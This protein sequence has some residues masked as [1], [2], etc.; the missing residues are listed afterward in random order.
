M[1]TRAQIGYVTD[2][3][4]V[5]G[6]Y[7]HWDGYPTGVGAILLEEYRTPEAVNALTQYEIRVLGEDGEVEYFGFTDGGLDQIEWDTEAHFFEDW[8]RYG[9][10]YHYLFKDGEWTIQ[11][12]WADDIPNEVTLN[13]GELLEDLEMNS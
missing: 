10:E 9:T 3:G 8:D 7:V 2:E 12:R 5:R 6:T 13:L 1:A 11:S 4:M